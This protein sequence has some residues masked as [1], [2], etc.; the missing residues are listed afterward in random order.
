MQVVLI[1][2][3]K[4]QRI[5]SLFKADRPGHAT[6]SSD[7]CLAGVKYIFLPAFMTLHGGGLLLVIC[8][9]GDCVYRSH[10]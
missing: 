4:S 10:E 7:G 8:N 5:G 1:S 3:K 2:G 6:T 9:T